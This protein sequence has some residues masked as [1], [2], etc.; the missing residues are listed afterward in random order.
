[1]EIV[2]LKNIL[3]CMDNFEKVMTSLKRMERMKER[4][5]EREERNT[6]SIQNSVW[7]NKCIAS[8]QLTISSSC[9]APHTDL[10]SFMGLAN[11]SHLQPASHQSRSQV[12]S[13]QTQTSTFFNNNIPIRVMDPCSETERRSSSIASLRLKAHEHSVAMG[14]LSVY[15]K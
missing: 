4:S 14:I 8:N 3:E 5:K 11:P 10:P 7:P 9:M 2:K 15:S 13:V 1:M 12:P 6:I